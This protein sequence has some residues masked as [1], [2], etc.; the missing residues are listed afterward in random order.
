[1]GKNIFVRKCSTALT[2][3]AVESKEIKNSY[4]GRQHTQSSFTTVS[5]VR[6]IEASLSEPHLVPYSGCAGGP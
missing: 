1:M 5:V 6:F 2:L 3:P 4:H